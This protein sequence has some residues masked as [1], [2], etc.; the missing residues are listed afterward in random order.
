[1]L[2][3]QQ[4][5]FRCN[6]FDATLVDITY[7]WVLGDNFEMATLST[8]AFYQVI[9]AAASFNF[10]HY[11]RRGW[12]Y[13]WRFVLICL[14]LYT[15]IS[16]A[17]LADPNVVGCL[18]RINCGNPDTL[19]RNG[20]AVPASTFSEFMSTLGH[21]VFPLQYRL[22]LFVLCVLNGLTVIL[23]EYFVVIGFVGEW[24][25]RKFGSLTKS[26]QIVKL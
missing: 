20:Y 15:L 12:I 24:L 17:L 25:K 10:G 21:N 16:Y 3:F 19:T 9:I 22:Q 5:W 7:W 13:N 14:A 6:E 26:S 1:V 18:L 2:L 23:W 4:D 8:V 11:F